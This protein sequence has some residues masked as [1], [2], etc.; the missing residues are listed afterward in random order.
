MTQQLRQPQKWI[1]PYRKQ[2][3]KI[4]WPQNWKQP[5]NED[6]PRNEDRSKNKCNL[7]N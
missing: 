7:K 4:W 5:Q 1:Q 2:P 6:N 3:H